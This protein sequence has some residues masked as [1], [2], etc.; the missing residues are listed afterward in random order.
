MP[1]KL[2]SIQMIVQGHGVCLTSPSDDVVD[3]LSS[4]KVSRIPEPALIENP[5]TFMCVVVFD[6]DVP[7][8]QLCSNRSTA[9]N[10]GSGILSVHLYNTLW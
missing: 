6:S 4:C 1:T 8:S 9:I 7:D 2:L 10:K 5:G 3:L